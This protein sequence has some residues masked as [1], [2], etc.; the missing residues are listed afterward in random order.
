MSIKSIAP[1]DQEYMFMLIKT[2]ICHRVQNFT[3]S[4]ISKYLKISRKTL[5]EFEKGKIY[6]IRLLFAYASVNGF[7]IKFVIDK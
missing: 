6:D 3:Q 2:I 4:E 7:N 1:E 5:I